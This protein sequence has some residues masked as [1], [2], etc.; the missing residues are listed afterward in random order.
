MRMMRNQR[1]ISQKIKNAWGKVN[2]FSNK[3]QNK[4]KSTFKKN[5][6]Y[7]LPSFPPSS[8]VTHPI[9]PLALFTVH[10]L[11]L[12]MDGCIKTRTPSKPHPTTPSASTHPTQPIIR[13]IR[14]RPSSFS[15]CFLGVLIL[16]RET[17]SSRRLCPIFEI[18][19]VV[20]PLVAKGE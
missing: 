19:V 2:I 16:N 14:H 7:R 3:I 12:R 18:F 1:S 20:G 5:L 4:G 15:G 9:H 8:H 10:V 11:P 17:A 13:R 6:P